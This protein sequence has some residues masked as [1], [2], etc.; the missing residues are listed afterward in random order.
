[1]LFKRTHRTR[2]PSPTDSAGFSVLELM[3]TLVI[4]GILVGI[5]GPIYYNNMEKAIRAEGEST[6]GSI[7][8]EVLAYYAEHGSYPVE[9]LD[10]IMAQDWHN[11][12]PGEMASVNFGDSSYYYQGDGTTY[13]IGLHRGDVL[14]LHRSLN[15]N[16]EYQD[17]DVK[18]NE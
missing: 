5:A 16:G 12:K 17:W 18:V 15:Q 11:I 6:L 10:L 13:L 14:E 9:T 4:V 7:R 8:N 1:M 2:P 3:I